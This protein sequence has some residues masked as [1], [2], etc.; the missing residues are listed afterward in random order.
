MIPNESGPTLN[1]GLGIV[2]GYVWTM[3]A[4]TTRLAETPMFDWRQRRRWGIGE[5]RLPENSIIRFREMSMW[6][7]FK[8]RIIAAIVMIVLQSLLIGGLLLGRRRAQ[9]SAAALVIAQRVLRE[10]EEWFRLAIQATNDA[11]WDIDLVTGT[12]SWNETYSTLYGRPP[13]PWKSWQ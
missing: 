5:D 3:E 12:V 10:G 11:I 13:E 1:V 9:Q 6:Q 7:Q 8:W 2:G 4:N